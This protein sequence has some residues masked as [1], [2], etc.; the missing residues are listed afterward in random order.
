MNSRFIPSYCAPA[1]SANIQPLASDCADAIQIIGRRTADGTWARIDETT[2]KGR[3]VPFVFARH[4]AVRVALIN[5]TALLLA[6]DCLTGGQRQGYQKCGYIF[7]LC[8]SKSSKNSLQTE[9][10]L[11]ST[12]ESVIIL[13]IETLAVF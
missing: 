7:H 9:N 6:Y 4:S 1:G 10:K 13:L 2:L 5:E 11:V 12:F 3:P 8:L